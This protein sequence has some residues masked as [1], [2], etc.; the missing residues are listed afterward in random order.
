M[1]TPSKSVSPEPHDRADDHRRQRLADGAACLEH[2]LRYLRLGWSVLAVCPPDH[3]GVGRSHGQHCDSPG[4]AP[5]GKWKQFQ[6]RVPTEA[7]LRQKWRDNPT[8]NVGM[9]L[10]PVSGLIR[11]DVDGPAGEARLIEVGNGDLPFTLEFTSGR[12]NGGRGLLFKIPTEISLRTTVQT[13][14]QTQQ[15]L[16]FQAKGAQTVLPPSRHPQ[17][18]LYAWVP[19]HSPWEIQA[20]MAPQWLLDQLQE[21]ARGSRKANAATGSKSLVD[22]EKIPEGLRDDILT[23]W[24][25][26][27]RRRGFSPEAIE[28]ALVVENALRCE[29]P[30]EEW[31]VKKIAKS[32]GMYAPAAR[33][34][35]GQ[36]RQ[37]LAFQFT[38]EI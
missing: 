5:W 3:V 30:L 19:G 17:G 23:S 8:L 14:G 21:N 11:V 37:P 1:S 7:E 36:R 10:G 6:D 18:C 27:M 24:A 22:G 29:P 16:R 34:N 12:A 25:G 33:T 35:T 15:E 9:A 32:V 20:A 26:T 31:Q 28:A 38:V 2:G 13:R 4:K